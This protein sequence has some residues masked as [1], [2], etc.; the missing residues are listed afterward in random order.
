MGDASLGD[1]DG[2]GNFEVVIHQA[3]QP[4]DNF[5]SAL[6]GRPILDSYQWDGSLLWR[7]N[8]GINMRDGK[9]YIQFMVYDLDGDGAAEVVCQ[10]G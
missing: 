9:H 6:A 10:D 2:D 7:L 3:K 4:R 5:H 8:L 1:L